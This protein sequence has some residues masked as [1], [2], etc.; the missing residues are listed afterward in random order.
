MN[1]IFCAYI[2]TL[3]KV[4]RIAE[5]SP[6]HSA[7]SQFIVQLA[8]QLDTEIIISVSAKD[9][10]V[11]DNV[12]LFERYVIFLEDLEDFLLK[13]AKKSSV[14]NFDN[15]VKEYQKFLSPLKNFVKEFTSFPEAV[16]SEEKF[17]DS[18]LEI[19]HKDDV[20][21]VEQRYGKLERG[22]IPKNSDKS[23]CWS[24]IDE[25]I[26]GKTVEKDSIGLTKSASWK[27]QNVFIKELVLGFIPTKMKQVVHAESAKLMRLN[28]DNI[29]S[30]LG[31]IIGP[32]YMALVLENH[33]GESL[34]SYLLR[35]DDLSWNQKYKFGLQIAKGL[36]FLHKKDILHGNL[37]AS[38]VYMD[39]SKN[40]KLSGFGL[41]ETRN[42]M[43]LYLNHPQV[44]YGL[45]PWMAPELLS[46]DSENTS[47]TDRYALGFTLWEIGARSIPFLGKPDSISMALILQK[48]RPEMPPSWD[49]GYRRLIN[50]LWRVEPGFR[51]ELGVVIKVISAL[52][53]NL[54]H[55][56]DMEANYYGNNVLVMK[57]AEPKSKFSFFKK[58]DDSKP[59]LRR[60]CRTWWSKLN[61]TQKVIL[62]ILILGLIGFLIAMI[63]LASFGVFNNWGKLDI[64]LRGVEAVVISKQRTH[65]H[66]V[67]QSNQVV[68]ASNSCSRSCY[69]SLDFCSFGLFSGSYFY[70]KKGGLFDLSEYL[71][72]VIGEYGSAVFFRNRKSYNTDS[73]SVS[74]F[75]ELFEGSNM[76]ASENFIV[77]DNYESSLS[78]IYDY[79]TSRLYTMEES[80]CSITAIDLTHVYVSCLDKI[81]DMSNKELIDVQSLPGQNFSPHSDGGILQPGGGLFL[82][83]SCSQG[84]GYTFCLLRK[85]GIIDTVIQQEFSTSTFY[86]S[87][88]F[89]YVWDNEVIFRISRSTYEVRQ[90]DMQLQS[91]NCAFNDKAVY[92]QYISQGVAIFEK[93]TF[94]DSTTE[95]I[96][97]LENA[98][99]DT[100]YSFDVD[101]D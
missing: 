57:K 95:R 65:L 92:Y 55:K 29:V 78:Q 86:K 63:V 98:S 25:F 85:N 23:F 73:Q 27:G 40:C 54:V 20:F 26:I 79:R 53:Q 75:T 76:R 41:I 66:L 16:F 51:P 83:T 12:N 64:D 5:S 72:Q 84:S 59:K 31:A 94:S 43:T 77:A 56:I 24:N 71:G 90:F 46:P 33:T 49:K 38:N 96:S 48:E 69:F 19:L 42:A 7:K 35:S 87:K 39:N 68:N 101:Y 100:I 2:D 21:S 4:T 34:L 6:F 50:E 99:I 80:S 88:S 28:H 10:F 61:I 70:S 97:E 47:Y 45:I 37:K 81:L 3:E 8:K 67:K 14:T 18:V 22:S 32:E 52:S 11:K 44:D 36:D 62:I 93:F 74:T 1:P 82:S 30:V 58:S 91:V 13:Q 17:D 89:I 15:A 9:R 60:S